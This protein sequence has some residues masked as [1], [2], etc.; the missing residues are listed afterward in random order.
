MGLVWE[1]LVDGGSSACGGGRR[2]CVEGEANIRLVY[3]LEVVTSV[4]L[5]GTTRP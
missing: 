2:Q 1:G 5:C 4:R 3:G